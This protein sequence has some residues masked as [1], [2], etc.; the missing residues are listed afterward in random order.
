MKNI[1]LVAFIS[2]LLL[3]SGF[4]IFFQETENSKGHDFSINYSPISAAKKIR[5]AD[6][7][8][9][10][11]L[12]LNNAK[13]FTIFTIIPKN[14]APSVQDFYLETN[15]DKKT[16]KND[17]ILKFTPKEDNIIIKMEFT[18]TSDIGSVNIILPKE[19]TDSLST[20]QEGEL[21]KEFENISELNLDNAKANELENILGEQLV[22]AFT[23]EAK[24][25]EK[26]EERVI[27]F[28]AEESQFRRIINSIRGSV[29]E[30]VKKYLA[31]GESK[32][33]GTSSQPEIKI[34]AYPR[35]FVPVKQ[36]TKITVTSDT[37]IEGID[38]FVFDYSGS[39]SK[40]LNENQK[41]IE[42]DK[43]LEIIWD[44]DGFQEGTYFIK[45]SKEGTIIELAQRS[46][47]EIR[48]IE[49]VIVRD[50]KARFDEIYSEENIFEETIEIGLTKNK[51]KITLK[52]PLFNPNE[53]NYTGIGPIEDF[54]IP[55]SGD[56]EINGFPQRIR[57]EP[58]IKLS[59]VDEEGDN[60]EWGEQPYTL[61]IDLNFTELL[62]NKKL[63]ETL[64]KE[65]KIDYSIFEGGYAP[66]IKLKINLNEPGYILAP[67]EF[68]EVAQET[69]T[70]KGWEFIEFENELGIIEV[71]GE[72]SFE[73]EKLYV[74]SGKTAIINGVS[75]EGNPYG[76]GNTFI[77]FDGKKEYEDTENYVS[78]VGEN[79]IYINN[80]KNN[81]SVKFLEGNPYFDIEENDFLRFD[82]RKKLV[83]ING[84]KSEGLIPEVSLLKNFG[85][86]YQFLSIRNGAITVEV[87]PTNKVHINQG[88]GFYRNS[89][90]R[91][92]FRILDEQG[93]DAIGKASN[94][95]KILFGNYNDF[96]QLPANESEGLISNGNLSIKLSE[97]LVV[98]EDESYSMENFGDEFP[99]I[100]INGEIDEHGLRILRMQLSVL[101]PKVISSIEAINFLTREEFVERDMSSA[102]AFASWN[103]M[104]LTIPI[105]EPNSIWTTAHESSHVYTF[106]IIRDQTRS[107]YYS[108]DS[109]FQTAWQEIAG[110]YFNQSGDPGKMRTRWPEDSG[111]E[112]RNGFARP[113]GANN[114]LEDVAT[115]TQLVYESPDQYAELINPKNENY[116]IR[117]VQK[118]NLLK[119]YEFIID[120]QYNYI[121]GK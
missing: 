73:N 80:A 5:F 34:F 78:F 6:G 50:R 117:F 97:K 27:Y 106:R 4:F 95:E 65:I 54:S 33:L 66:P 84:R 108:E 86:K 98:I 18:N 87:S 14:L 60:S 30:I 91:F 83:R 113:Y 104:S 94:P 21:L 112:P 8:R 115:L 90:T 41:T 119:E 53:V 20:E 3:I 62:G 74:S 52:K 31:S 110:E 37:T 79:E 13:E 1:L 75:I 114:F 109:E 40:T 68:S 38:V 16:L 9:S 121:T 107:E 89:S 92:S 47:P 28:E 103:G 43:P 45:A 105:V 17:P 71:T 120:K 111:T 61:V 24:L 55:N 118:L 59:V 23:E 25:E 10:D 96:I 69:A 11:H 44:G 99:H 42:K 12:F 2:A 58:G 57:T 56:I 72:I 76:E 51:P 116:D 88:E 67:Q 100:T 46:I 102:G 49:E 101:A 35:E 7:K 63:P 48:L 82:G 39:F 22:S 77:Y 36:K 32:Q 64:E 85:D 19:F 15:A 81:F 93:N 70:K 26:K 29:G